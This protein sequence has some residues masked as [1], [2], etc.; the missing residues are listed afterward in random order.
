MLDS[1]SRV[2]NRA[3]SGQCEMPWHRQLG[4]PE[5][6]VD[7]A[8]GRVAGAEPADVR[9]DAVAPAAAQLADRTRG[10]TGAPAAAAQHALGNG[11][12]G[13]DSRGAL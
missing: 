7:G 11:L 10:E 8:C 13:R 12:S 4:R 3:L 5:E 2:E 9:V 1:T 6:G